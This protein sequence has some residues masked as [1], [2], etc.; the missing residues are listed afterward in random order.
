MGKVET[1]SPVMTALFCPHNVE[2]RKAF[3]QQDVECSGSVVKGGCG[4]DK[5]DG[6]DGGRGG[7]GRGGGGNGVP[8]PK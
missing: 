7:G 1:F 2:E 6:S 8:P 5:G 3:Q 4:C